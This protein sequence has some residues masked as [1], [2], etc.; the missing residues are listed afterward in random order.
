[1]YFFIGT[2]HL[3]VPSSWNV[4]VNKTDAG[5]HPCGVYIVMEEDREL[6]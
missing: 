3:F 5:L 6:M 4:V 2:S 1:M